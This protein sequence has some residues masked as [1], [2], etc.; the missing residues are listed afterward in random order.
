ML[1]LIEDVQ[2][3]EKVIFAEPAFVEFNFFI[4]YLCE[5]MNGPVDR[6]TRVVQTRL[7]INAHSEFDT[8][9]FI[10]KSC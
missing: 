8:G 7:E 1:R 9:L 5:F 2:H 3:L 10:D 4:Y 6:D